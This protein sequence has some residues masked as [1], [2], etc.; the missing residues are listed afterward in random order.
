L[1][2]AAAALVACGGAL[3]A[4]EP[5]TLAPGGLIP[6]T[7]AMETAWDIPRNPLTDT[8]LAPSPL[9]DQIRRGFEIFTDTPRKAPRF[10][11]NALTCGN[12][13]LNAGQ[14]DRALPLV[15]VAAAFPE[16]NKR[17]GEI[18]SL[19]DRIVGCFL[20]S[21]NG[22]AR[23]APGKKGVLP[24]ASSPEVL[25]VSAYIAWLSAGRPL[26]KEIPWRGHNAIE[27]KRLVPVDSLDAR[28]GKALFAERCANCHGEDGQGVAIGDK[29]PGPLWGPR[30]WNDGAGAARVYTL[31]GM[32]RQYMPYIDPGSL[33]DVEAQQIAYYINSRPRP[34]FPFKAGDYATDKL[35]EDA[36]Y[37]KRTAKK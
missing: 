4:Q 27:K 1:I 25:A 37:Y 19:E 33:T 18:I 9:T 24:T 35:P 17:Q 23:I 12:C 16:Y 32:I 11:G 3:R 10:S 31:A 22:T 5:D 26:G 13:H 8:T 6:A 2:L 36:L 7:T 21:L 28:A 30:S 15:G 34:S 20:R 14:R 29:K